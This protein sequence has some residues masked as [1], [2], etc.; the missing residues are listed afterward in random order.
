MD[1]ER[2]EQVKK[3][4]RKL[5]HGDYY[6][7]SDYAQALCE[8]GTLVGELVEEVERLSAFEARVK[9]RLAEQRVQLEL[10]KQDLDAAWKSGREMMA[11]NLSAHRDYL[12]V[13]I[14]VMRKL[15]EE[16]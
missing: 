16:D 4:L 14:K 8:T 9:T 6:D 7:T 12:E 15:V 3:D 11:R 5:E 13:E 2:L 1:K 10:V